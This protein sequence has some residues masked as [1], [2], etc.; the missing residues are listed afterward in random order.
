MVSMVQHT[1]KVTSLLFPHRAGFVESSDGSR[2]DSFYYYRL[3]KLCFLTAHMCLFSREREGRI[4]RERETVHSHLLGHFPNAFTS[5][6]QQLGIDLE[7]AGRQNIAQASHMVAKDPDTCAI[8]CCL[9]KSARSWG[10]VLGQV[11]NP[12]IPI[13]NMDILTARLYTCLPKPMTLS[14]GD[15]NFIN[16]QGDE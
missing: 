2:N 4:E 9:S 12:S 13:W 11:L 10:Q 5:T 7:E 3:C 16:F 1:V 6:T 14:F 15:L 8:T